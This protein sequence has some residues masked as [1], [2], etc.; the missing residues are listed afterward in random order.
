MENEKYVRLSGKYIEGS[1]EVN[2]DINPATGKPL[3][4]VK[5]MTS[6]D[7]AE[8]VKKAVSA[9]SLWS[10]MTPPARGRILYKAGEIAESEKEFL[11]T[12]MTEEEGKTYN[13]SLS[14][15]TRSIELLK[16]Y[17][18]LSFKY[19]GIVLPSS[20]Q[21][22]RIFTVRVPMGIVGLIS[23]WN[24]PLSIPVWKAAPALAMGNTAVMKP[25]SKTPILAAA[26]LD[27]LI[28]AGLPENVMSLAVGPGSEVGDA[29]VKSDDISAIS[30]TGSVSVG[31]RIYKGVAEKNGVTRVQLELGGKN[32]VYVDESADLNLAVNL[33]LRGS[34]GLT[35][36]SCTATSRLII[37]KNVYNKVRDGLLSAVKTWRVG[38]GLE[39]E[40]NMGPVVDEQQ[41]NTD[42]DY[43]E[44]G[45]NEGAR[46][47]A[48]GSLIKDKESTLFLQPTIFDSVTQD[49]KIFREEIFG[50]VLSI[51]VADNLDHAINLVNSV[52]Y[53][54]TSAIFATN[55]TAIN[56][57]VN[58]V[59][60]GVIKVNKPTVGLELQAPFGTLKSSGANTWKEM[61][62]SA[63]EFYSTEKTVYQGW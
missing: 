53:G 6:E 62:E 36:Q 41:L 14:E 40:T 13:D 24:F 5:N 20:D 8:A 57:F 32:A 19:G 10:S 27:T 23:P 39:K 59:R 37:H 3:A 35:G 38:N 49:M 50:P 22:T 21:N 48:G 45:K 46:L 2:Y 63:L 61:G 1:G 34:F 15:V 54:H 9:Y 51:T 17:G 55:N 42:L 58:E 29:I 25:A 4:K 26:F 31:N 7:A 56:R 28:R 52:D 43:I 18:M 60:T 16:F 33:T 11:A 12:L 30:F 47:I 44:A